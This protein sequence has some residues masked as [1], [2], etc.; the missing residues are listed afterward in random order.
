MNT[1]SWRGEHAAPVETNPRK[2]FRRLFGQGDSPEQRRRQ[3]NDDQ[4]ILDSVLNDVSRLQR[5][6]DRQTTIA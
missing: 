1:L 4:S 3:L 2:V 6:L 5:A